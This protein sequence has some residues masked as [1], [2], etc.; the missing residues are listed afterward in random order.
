MPQFCIKCIN[1]GLLVIILIGIPAITGARF[2]HL[3]ISSARTAQ[4]LKLWGLSLAL[5]GNSVAALSM[6]K[7]RK[8]QALCCEWAL[9]FASLFGIEYALSHGHLNFN[10]LKQSL[11]W[12][13]KHL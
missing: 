5:V 6:G 3:E 13:Q 10:W 12:L 8:E 11:L 1:C 7:A 2:G 9:V 4:A